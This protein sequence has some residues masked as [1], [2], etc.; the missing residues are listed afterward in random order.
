[1][2]DSGAVVFTDLGAGDRLSFPVDERKA[3]LR[4]GPA[5]WAFCIRTVLGP[6]QG[7]DHFAYRFEHAQA[8]IA[9]R[10]LGD[11]SINSLEIIN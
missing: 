8:A 4:V 5:A 11:T 2:A 1:M 6:A 10:E 9:A 3:S 7:V